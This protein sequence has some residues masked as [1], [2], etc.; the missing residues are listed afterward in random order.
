MMMKKYIKDKNY[1]KTTDF[2]K[3]AFDINSQDIR[4]LTGMPVISRK[5]NKKLNI[6]NNKTFTIKEI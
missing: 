4:L 6:F 3:L 2:K 5:N 1:K